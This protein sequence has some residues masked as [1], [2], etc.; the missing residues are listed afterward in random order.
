VSVA[1]GLVTMAAGAA[2][3]STTTV[4]KTVTVRAKP[5]VSSA[6][7]NAD[8]S[9]ASAD[10]MLFDAIQKVAQTVNVHNP[11]SESR[12][13]LALSA[14]RHRFDQ[15]LANIPF[16][17]SDQADVKALLVADTAEEDALVNLSTAITTPGN[18][19]GSAIDAEKATS[20]RFDTAE[21]AVRYDTN[22]NK[23]P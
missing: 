2:C 10:L 6:S 4:T 7:Y 13:Y 23:S 15:A 19:L 9:F 16:P 3:G 14:A 12:G 17:V 5:S 11:K 1:A 8:V 20:S 21:T 18:N 22:P